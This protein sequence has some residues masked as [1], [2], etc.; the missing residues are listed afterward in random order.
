MPADLDNNIL[1]LVEP[2]IEPKKIEVEA[3]GEDTGDND[4]ITKTFGIQSPVIVINEY[5]FER[6]NIKSFT[7]S[8]SD[9]LPTVQATLIDTKDVFG[10]DAFPRDGDSMTVFINS[11]NESTFKAIHLDFEITD[12][13]ANPAKEGDPKK[14]NVSGRVKIPK[15][16]S[17]N[18][19]YLE[20][21]TSMNHLTTVAK[22]LKLGLASNI[23]ETTDA[24]TRIQAYISY[25]DFITQIVSSSYISDDSFQNFF[26]DQYYYLNFIDVNRI[27]NSKN[28]KLEEFQ[29]TMASMSVSMA[30]EREIDESVDSTPTKLFLTN[31]VTFR[32]QNNYIKQYRIINSSNVISEVHGHFRDVQIYDDNGDPKLDE[33]RVEALS[34][35]PENLTDIQ[36]PLKGNRESEDYLSMIKHKYMG[37]QDVGE[38]GL[39][40]SHQNYIYSQLHNARNID[41][42]QKLKLEVTLEGFNPGLYRY[43]K[44]PV[45]MYQYDAKTIK[46]AQALEDEKKND[47]FK[48]STIETPEFKEPD[49][50]QK[51][52]QFLS[53]YYIIESIDMVYK[54]NTSGNFIQKVTLIRR[55][56]PAR[57]H[58]IKSNT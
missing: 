31:N 10:V 39:G 22:E 1:A 53:G 16:F 23:D 4:K 51:L 20:T 49:P 13:T 36:E 30:E 58:A 21:D 5:P 7:L 11:K 8:S 50:D 27:F 33:F 29:E 14:I 41:E 17:E 37:R 32:P 26:I 28:P 35:N 46:S 48:D 45:L 56:W 43:L 2:A 54:A 52:D 18:C 3:R 25:I 57:L 9:I 55:D 42:T 15:L 6:T 44:I 38:D 34:T 40:N 47:G 12:I 19:Q 24:Q